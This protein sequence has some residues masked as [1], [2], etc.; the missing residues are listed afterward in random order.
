MM[1]RVLMTRVLVVLAVVMAAATAFFAGAPTA[2]AAEV[3]C[4]GTLGGGSA[5][6]DINGNVS[7]PDNASCILN[8]VNV[9]GNVTTGRNSS[10]LITAYT[11]PSTISGNVQAMQC[12][13][14][15]LQGFV[16][17]GGNV[18]IQQCT[19]SGP[20]GFIG[21]SIF[22]GGNFQCQG[23]SS[24]AEPCVAWLGD[25]KGDVQI[26]S[27]V[28]LTA[29]DVSLVTVGGNLHCQSNTP[30]TTHVHGSDWVY[31]RNEDQDHGHDQDQD[32]GHDQDRE[33]GYDEN[34]CAGFATTK[35]QIDPPGTPVASCAALASLPASGFPVPNT[36]ITSAVDTPASGSLPERCIVNGYV[37]RH[38]SPVDNCTY[39]DGFQVQLPLPAAWNH[40]YLGQGGG[41]TEGSVPAATGT[42]GGSLGINE[43]S[44]GYAVASQDGGHENSFLAEPTCGIP[45]P[46]IYSTI[47]TAGYGNS[48]E[49]FLDPWGVFASVRESIE[50]MTLNAKYLINQYYGA[51]PDRSYWA[52]CSAG[53]HEGMTNSQT[54]PSYFDGILAGDPAGPNQEALGLTEIYGDEAVLALYNYDLT[55]LTYP[56]VYAGNSTGPIGPLEFYN[57]SSPAPQ[58]LEP[59]VYPAFPLADANPPIPLSYGDQ[60]LV[61]TALLQYC[62]PLDGLTDGVVDNVPACEDPVSGFNPAIYS[63]G[64]HYIDYNGVF[65]PPNTTYAL[66][67]TSNFTKKATCLTPEQIQTIIKIHSGPRTGSG[68]AIYVPAGVK[69]VSAV[70]GYSYDGGWATT[71]GMAP[72]K[73]GTSASNSVP[74]DISLNGGQFPYSFLHPADPA[75]YALGFPFTPAS[76]AKLQSSNPLVT[77]GGSLDLS[78]FINYGHKIIWYHGASDPGPSY[79][80]TLLYYTAMAKQYGGGSVAA[81][82]SFSRLYP[83]PNLDHCTGGATTDGFDLLTPLVNWVEN[84]NAPSTSPATAITATSRATA[85]NATTYQA[86]GDYITSAPVNS[87]P[88]R[89]RPLCPYPQQ[90]RFTGTVSV[91]NGLRLA[92]PS[93]QL[94]SASNYTCVPGPEHNLLPYYP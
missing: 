84:G 12:K 24:N 31:G 93:S 14:A 53:G 56:Y 13:S 86:L 36:V 4:S 83:I 85:Y 2:R 51:D 11:E 29:S 21:P 33:H 42:I 20:N 34:Q 57:T 54:F 18:Q 37:N 39:Q 69:P 67:C 8:F 62:D 3:T 22:I 7:V 28:G 40:R 75:Y 82:Q 16:T 79:L 48:F 61:E 10:L 38:V 76:I 55:Y 50:V 80:T 87:P 49:F 81:A 94:G 60:G 30:H 65:G 26:Q 27:N 44:N 74:G 88:Q 89:T 59:H 9:T 25:V 52:G 91:V 70:V 92:T 71:V 35:T 1:P 32:H 47:S 6:T 90:L 46:N 78:H 64:G 19:G 41:G 15:L 68:A 73:I 77:Y 5:V 17:V 43:I 58:A 72:R 63:Q 45:T 66:Q 23:N